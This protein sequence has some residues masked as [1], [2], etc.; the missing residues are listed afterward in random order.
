MP[1]PVSVIANSTYCPGSTS[2]CRAAYA[3]SRAAFAISIVSLPP[4]GIASRALI[5][6]FKTA[7]WNSD[8]S[9]VVFH[10]PPAVMHS[11]VIDSPTARR[12]SGSVSCMTWS[13]LT[14]SGCSGWR[15]AKARSCLVNLAARSAAM[16]IMSIRSLALSSRPMVRRSNP[17]LPMITVSRL[18]KSWATPPVIWPIDSS[19]CA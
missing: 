15:L 10:N 3:S 13:R 19:F 4:S 6:R 17:K 2:T 8:V 12:T 16:L 14:I 18:L 7:D 5:A 9:T 1:L 11:T